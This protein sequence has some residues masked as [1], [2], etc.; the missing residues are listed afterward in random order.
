MFDGGQVTTIH[1][2]ETISSNLVD[3]LP[4]YIGNLAGA[5]L[6]ALREA[7]RA[8]HARDL[9]EVSAVPA[10][11]LAPRGALDL[12]SRATAIG[13]MWDVSARVGYPDPWVDLTVFPPGD[14]IPTDVLFRV[15]WCDGKV[16]ASRALGRV[17]LATARKKLAAL[18]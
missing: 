9:R 13:L 5:R 11:L 7:V 18:E 12:V 14:D 2:I 1:Y 16:S 4:R 15:S 10:E 6:D 3:F 17:T 8:G